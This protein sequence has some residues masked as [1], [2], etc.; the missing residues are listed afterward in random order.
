MRGA[1]LSACDERLAGE[2][3]HPHAARV[4][5]HLAFRPGQYADPASIE[6]ADEKA[7][8]HQKL[9]AVGV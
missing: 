3:Q 1:G 9:D 7:Q 6:S 4:W 5:R 2:G 8:L